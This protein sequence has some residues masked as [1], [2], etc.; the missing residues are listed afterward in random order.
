VLQVSPSDLRTGVR[1]PGPRRCV[2]PPG[3]QPAASG[4]GPSGVGKGQGTNSKIGSNLEIHNLERVTRIELA[5]SAWEADVLP[6]NY[7]RVRSHRLTLPPAWTVSAQISYRTRQVPRVLLP[8]RDIKAEIESGRVKLDPYDPGLIQPSSIDVRMDRYF[9]VFENHRYR[10]S[11]PQG[12][13][14]T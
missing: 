5:L 14:R 8:D 12:S 11:I 6:L 4:A 3:P 1:M 10:T 7:T 9:R 13:S 2:G